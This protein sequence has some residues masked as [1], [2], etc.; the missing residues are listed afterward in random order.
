MHARRKNQLMKKT[1]V[2]GH[3]DYGYPETYR[4]EIVYAVRLH[5]KLNSWRLPVAAKHVAHVYNIS[6]RSVY[7]WLQKEMA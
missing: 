3:A 5:M 4:E 1:L 7:R 2:Y 6:P